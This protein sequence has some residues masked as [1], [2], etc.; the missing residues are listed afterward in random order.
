MK[1]KRTATRTLKKTFAVPAVMI[2]LFLFA[3]C[4]GT[5]SDM[6]RLMARTQGTINQ[7]EKISA[8]ELYRII[9][10]HFGRVNVKMIDNE[11]T[12][13]DNGKVAELAGNATRLPWDDLTE[14]DDWDCDDY[15]IAAMVPLR[16]YAF[17]AMYVKT[18]SGSRHAMNVFVNR[19]RE[20]F[21]WEPQTR[22]YY[23]GRFHK[24]D[25]IIF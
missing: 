25:L 12:L 14:K 9:C 23:R 5:S 21:Y 3:G 24:P 1:S 11:Y 15:A 7:S 18:A 8:D 4:A 10:N 22:D 20:V 13:P 2:L 19:N 17:G 16:N 6:D